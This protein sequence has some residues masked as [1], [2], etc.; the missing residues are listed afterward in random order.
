LDEVRGV[1]GDDYD[2]FA[3]RYGLN[4]KAN[5]ERRW[6][7]RLAAP[8]TDI[9]DGQAD[10]VA[11]LAAA[12]ARLLDAREARVRPGRDDKILTAWNALCIR[13]L[14]DIGQQLDRP[15]CLLAAT[16]A[17]DFLHQTHW[18][19]DRLLAT[20]RGGEA[21]LNAYLDDYAFLIDAL[22]VLL[23]ARW[24]ARD[25][26]FAIALADA[27]LE[28]FEDHR[29]GG[30]F[31]TS[32]DHESLIQRTKSFGDDS[33][34]S[35]NGTAARAL[36]ELGYLVGEP[37]YLDAAERTLRAGMT[38]A[39][40]WPS[41]H[42]TLMRAL[43]DHA[44]PPPRVILRCSEDTDVT[45]WVTMAAERLPVRSRCYLI[46]GDANDLPGLLA[47]R[48]AQEGASVTAYYCNG[49][50]CSAPA[51]SLEVFADSLGS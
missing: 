47:S 33:L 22:L 44:T 18:R 26:T 16:R 29:N 40:R 19:N 1:L 21:H 12:R 2:A 35:G 15:D 3:E 49:H 13:G 43:L 8:D 41:A 27:L 7:L 48:S 24:R 28:H 9:P 23:S 31:F 37:R 10:P 11:D 46:P 51:S 50:Q 39:G 5:F 36:L 42:A 30:F 20:S 17:V 14:A 25:L 6:H 32:S 38:D 4:D 34:P 45:A